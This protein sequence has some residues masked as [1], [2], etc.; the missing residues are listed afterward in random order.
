META[1]LR[2]LASELLQFF[3]YLRA[4]II[5][6]I[7]NYPSVFTHTQLLMMKF[8]SQGLC[9]VSE[10]A[11]KRGI[12]MQTVSEQISQL[13]EMGML[14]RLRDPNDKRKWLFHM[15][16]KGQ[17]E[18]QRTNDEIVEYISTYLERLT[19]EE[20]AALFTVLAALRRAFSDVSNTETLQSKNE[21]Q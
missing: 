10:I 3:P 20:K 7:E 17:S 15:T 8:I 6:K 2:Q 5:N 19:E 11:Q 18:H 14:E 4:A 13:E 9:T 21:E 12:S 16:E 1:N